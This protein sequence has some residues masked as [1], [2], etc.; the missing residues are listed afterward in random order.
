M[1]TKIVSQVAG[2]AFVLTLTGVLV[3]SALD[4]HHPARDHP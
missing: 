3:Q 2:V 1:E 4:V